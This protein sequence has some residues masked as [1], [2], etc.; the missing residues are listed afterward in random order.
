MILDMFQERGASDVE[1]PDAP[2]QEHISPEDAI[3]KLERLRNMLFREP[4]FE[5]RYPEAYKELFTP[6]FGGMGSEHREGTGL[7]LPSF[8]VRILRSAPKSV[9]RGEGEEH[10]ADAYSTSS[11]HAEMGEIPITI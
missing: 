8:R 2:R 9:V 1:P 6:P 5:A 4:E 11:F 3:R 10:S 7:P